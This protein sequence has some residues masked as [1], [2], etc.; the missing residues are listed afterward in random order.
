M[1]FGGDHPLRPKPCRLAV[2]ALLLVGLALIT[3]ASIGEEIARPAGIADD[4][5]PA[6]TA[7]PAPVLMQD[8]WPAT[9]SA[10][11]GDQVA[12][13]AVFS[14]SPAAIF[15]WQKISNGATNDIFGATTT[16]LTLTDLQPAI[17]LLTG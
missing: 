1:T 11:I 17:L 13:T 3:R 6:S 14:D 5:S 7:P 16:T 9:A 8:A 10:M 15:Q 12:F 4:N 2:I